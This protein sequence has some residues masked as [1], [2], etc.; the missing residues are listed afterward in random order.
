MLIGNIF[1]I[2]AT[3]VISSSASSFELNN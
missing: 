2:V 1:F 3:V